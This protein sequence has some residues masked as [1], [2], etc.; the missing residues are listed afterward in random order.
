MDSTI[1]TITEGN[2]EKLTNFIFDSG[3]IPS[4]SSSELDTSTIP[5]GNYEYHCLFYPFMT[6]KL[7]IQ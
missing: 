5:Q 2:S 4:K 6:G 1:H 3:I 7:N